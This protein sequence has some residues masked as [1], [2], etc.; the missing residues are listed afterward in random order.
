MKGT[1]ESSLGVLVMSLMGTQR[2]WDTC[3]RKATF[4]LIKYVH[5]RP[6]VVC[7]REH[8]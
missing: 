6:A 1:H 5:N 8:K 7:Y 3:T 2:D 4:V